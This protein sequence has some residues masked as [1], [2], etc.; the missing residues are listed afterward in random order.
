MKVIISV[1]RETEYT[2]IVEMEEDTFFAFKDA[3]ESSGKIERTKAETQ[4]N[5]LIDPRDWMDDTFKNLE[6]FREYKD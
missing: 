2:S 1:I 3:L 6:D 5:R 4:I